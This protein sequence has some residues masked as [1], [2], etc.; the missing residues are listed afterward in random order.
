MSFPDS[1]WPRSTCSKKRRRRSSTRSV[2]QCPCSNG[3]CSET[4]FVFSEQRRRKSLCFNMRHLACWCAL[5]RK[6]L[7][8]VSDGTSDVSEMSHV[9]HQ[10][11]LT[12]H[13]TSLFILT[14]AIG[15]LRTL[16]IAQLR[17]ILQRL[18]TSQGAPK[19][20][21]MRAYFARGARKSPTSPPRKQ[22][23]R[24]ERHR[25][26][27]FSSFAA[28]GASVRDASLASAAGFYLS[29]HMYII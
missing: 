25:S 22:G 14:P 8:L 3:T 4:F 24:R 1:C 26:R 9:G 13:S 7:F 28:L 19:R 27:F 18:S 12:L 16:R 20:R 29:V 6:S 21:A 15:P 10:R 17:G 23:N 2:P 11:D 5:R